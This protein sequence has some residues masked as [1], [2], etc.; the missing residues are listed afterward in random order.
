MI[1][2]LIVMTVGAHAQGSLQFNQVKL[3]ADVTETVPTGKVWKIESVYSS[4]GLY[5]GPGTGSWGVN[6]LNDCNSPCYPGFGSTGQQ[7]CVST[8]N[9]WIDGVEISEYDLPLWLPEG[10]TLRS[11]SKTCSYNGQYVEGVSS[12]TGPTCGDCSSYF[13][14]GTHVTGTSVTVYSKVSVLEFHVVPQ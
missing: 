8:K 11:A 3:V 4:K 12:W 6:H 5:W 9:L 1:G 13:M 10:S 2:L 14:T 7:Q